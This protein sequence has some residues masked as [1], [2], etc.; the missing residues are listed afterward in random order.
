MPGRAS[1]ARS[2]EAC[3][4]A[5]WNEIVPSAVCRERERMVAALSGGIPARSRGAR[6]IP[7]G[8][9]KRRSSPRPA[10]SVEPNID[11][12]L[13]AIAVM[14]RAELRCARTAVTA[15][16]KPS[17]APGARTPGWRASRLRRSESAARCP[18]MT[19]GLAPRSKRARVRSTIESRARG[20]GNRTSRP[21]ANRD[22]IGDTSMEPLLPS[23]V[24]VRR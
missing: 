1:R 21:S 23:T 15:S 2:A 19:A 4:N 6:A 9:G 11:A 5:E 16:S 8:V 14:A 20:S 12:S 7:A 3:C 10:V 13:P 18:P 22:G 24:M 17:Q